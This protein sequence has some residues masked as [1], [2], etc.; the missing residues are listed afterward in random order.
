MPAARRRKTFGIDHLASARGVR[1]PRKRSSSASSGRHRLAERIN[2]AAAPETWKNSGISTDPGRWRGHPQLLK[3]RSPQ[4]PPSGG[5]LVPDTAVP[6]S[7]EDGTRLS[8]AA[9]TKAPRPEPAKVRAARTAP[10][11]RHTPR[12]GRLQ[13]QGGR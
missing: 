5:V 7:F 10:C 11:S 2:S 1:L 13:S 8:D 6:A 9:Q 12:F 3:K 4:K